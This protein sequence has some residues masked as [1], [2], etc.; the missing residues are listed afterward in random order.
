MIVD[1]AGLA[2]ADFDDQAG[3]VFQMFDGR[4]GIDASLESMAGI[5]REIEAAGPALDGGRPPKRSLRVNVARRVGHSGR[6]AAHDAGQRL[7]PEPVGNHAD[8]RVHSNRRSVEQLELFAGTAPAH[9]ETALDPVQV[10]DVGGP[11]ILKHHVVRNVDQRSD[12]ALPATRQ[13]LHHP[14]RR[15][16]SR[17]DIADDPA[18]KAAAQVGRTDC[19]RQHRRVRRWHRFDRRRPQR[20]ASQRRQLT[21]HAE[22]AQCMGQVGRELQGEH[23]V[24][25]LEHVAHICA[26]RRLGR[27]FEQATMVFAQLQ[28]AGRAQHALAFD[29]AQLTQLDQ[30]RLAV[31]ARRQFGA[32]QGARHLDADPRVRR[33][34]DDV[35]QAAAANIDLAHAQA[36]GIRMLDRLPDFADHDLRE[37]WR[38]RS[39]LFHLQPAHG[40]RIGQLLAC[41][42][43]IAEFA[44]PGLGKLHFVVDSVSG[45]GRGNGR[46]LR[47]TGARRSHRSGAWQAVPP[48]CR[49]RNRGSAPGPAPCC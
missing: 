30:E 24:V 49:K 40:Q 35:Q 18:R 17:I 5:G 48:P 13:P 46:R 12:T 29:T 42:R 2:A 22:H 21:G 47:R 33:T 25:E 41:E 19:Y 16:R 34:T 28:F 7:H 4:A 26:N 14:G 44:Q 36:I 8:L 39:Q 20:G 10:E 6:I 43:R 27:Q 15:L 3:D 9:V 31:L 32:D 23:R 1:G 11:A 38:R 45:T 37:R